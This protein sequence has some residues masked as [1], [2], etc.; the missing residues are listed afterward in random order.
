MLSPSSHDVAVSPAIG[1]ILLVAM[2]VVFVAVVAVV[3]TGL[4]GG[5][6]ASK[7][8]GLTLT[9]YAVDGKDAEHGVSLTVYGGKDAGDLVSL[10]ASITDASL[11]YAGT[12][13]NYV[14][15]PTIGP[16]YQFAVE[17]KQVINQVNV[18]D[19]QAEITTTE[20]NNTG[21]L[22]D[23]YVTITGK[24]RDGS[25]QVLLIQK[26]TIPAVTDPLA[27]TANDYIT[28]TP[29]SYT[30]GYPGH[31]LIIAP[32]PGITLKDVSPVSLEVDGK[33][34]R[35]S[36]KRNTNIKDSYV[37]DVPTD[38]VKG[39]DNSPYPDKDTYWQ[40]YEL[41]GTATIMFTVEGDSTSQS[42]SV[43]VTIPP[44][45]NIFEGTG[46]EIGSIQ[47]TTESDKK[48]IKIPILN[49][50]SINW[51][52]R[53]ENGVAVF[54]NGANHPPFT[55]SVQFETDNSM[56]LKQTRCLTDVTG[57]TATIEVFVK[58]KVA[59]TV[60]WYRIV[61]NTIISLTQQTP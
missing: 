2:T 13:S 19:V 42:V 59:P 21:E 17:M 12:Q 5:M 32:L 55:G 20:L 44:R 38:T 11:I 51:E 49:N 29:F 37:F 48:G 16:S 22:K 8:V 18:G 27:A 33:N 36:L 58:I 54:V 1:T 7:D 50:G 56:Y 14:E 46:V 40:L 35:L 31:G 9:P 15:F 34:E 43:P 4:A 24:F 61:P 53:V 47:V 3:V 28:V 10:S 25:E 41:T 30:K 57:V 26:V 60:V 45:V 52:N 39:W 23:R 6:F